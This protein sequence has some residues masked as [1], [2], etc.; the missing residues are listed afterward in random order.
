MFISPVAQPVIQ[1]LAS[2]TSSLELITPSD[3]VVKTCAREKTIL[4]TFWDNADV[5]VLK[6]HDTITVEDL[7]PLATRT[8]QE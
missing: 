7:K 1:C 6:A 5:A 4:G 2:P 8:S 3:E